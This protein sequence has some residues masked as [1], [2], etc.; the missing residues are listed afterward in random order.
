MDSQNNIAPQLFF[1]NSF[2]INIDENNRLNILL[3]GFTIVMLFKS[4]LMV[5]STG[6]NNQLAHNLWIYWADIIGKS[7][8]NG[9]YNNFRNE[10][11]G[12][13]VHNYLREPFQATRG[14]LALLDIIASLLITIA[15]FTLMLYVNWKLTLLFS[16]F[17]LILMLL[18]RKRTENY[19][20][21]VGIKR[22]KLTQAVTAHMTELLSLFKVVR[23][24]SL[25]R[26]LHDKSVEYLKKI[27]NVNVKF[28]IFK[29][30]PVSLTEFVIVFFIMSYIV[31][32]VSIMK[33]N[34]N[35]IFPELIFF[36]ASLQRLYANA[37]KIFTLNMVFV[38]SLPSFKLIESYLRAFNK[39]PGDKKNS[40]HLE[41]LDSDI[42]LKNISYA[43]KEGH[44]VLTDLCVKIP[45]GK[46]TII[47]GQS[48][49]G[50]STLVNILLGLVSAQSGKIC[51]GGKDINS[52]DPESW[53]SHIGYVSQDVVL[54]HDSVLNNIRFGK[55][56]ASID[57]VV[58]A[59]EASDA[60]DFIQ[61]LPSGYETIIGD[62]GDSLSGG[63]KQRISIAR[64]LVRKPDLLILDE[65]TS[66]L[67]QKTEKHVIKKIIQE[68]KRMTIV[69]ITHRESLLPYADVVYKL[70]DGKVSERLLS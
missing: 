45:Q 6:V 32:G 4:L 14:M 64:A 40:R 57:D 12:K 37:S 26:L 58:A 35:D 55:L 20:R 66:A 29:S 39:I 17:S 67:D 23:A 53:R 42:V 31:V 62:R 61:R 69:F 54:F 36:A 60:H 59:A 70:E 43:Y 21:D 19:S 25:E 1:I 34:V 30:V 56:D 28:A 22:Q 11:Q 38:S 16:L 27:K 49:S 13:L 15:V 63:Q 41:K 44:P 68:N 18:I 46:V 33:Q 5:V 48:G 51:L 9:S 8:I 52:Y 50:K 10:K 3:F 65:A 2:L 7:I 24:F 47:F